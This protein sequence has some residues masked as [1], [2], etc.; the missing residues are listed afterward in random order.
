MP[1]RMTL[2]K[3]QIEQFG[4]RGVLRLDGLLDGGAVTAAQEFV[5]R[6]VERMGVLAENRWDFSQLD[7]LPAYKA[8]SRLAKTIGYSRSFAAVMADAQ[9][10]AEALAGAAL[11][12]MLD[13]PTFLA[14]TPRPGPWA[15]PHNVWHLDL[16]KAQDKHGVPGVQV[17][18]MLESLGPGGGGTV[19]LAGS[20]P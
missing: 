19:V 11:V 20:H 8:N 4:D 14:S 3:D 15:L 12:P 1:S 9:P 6:G 10:L 7:A 13:R 2:T 17:F 5:R 16:P 18:A